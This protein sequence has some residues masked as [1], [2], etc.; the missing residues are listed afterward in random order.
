MSALR[1]LIVGEAELD[2]EEGDESFDEETGEVRRSKQG[3]NGL[4]G[5][6]GHYDDSSEEEED[7]NDEEAARQVIARAQA[8]SAEIQ[9]M[10]LLSMA[11]DQ[12]RLHCRRR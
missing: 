7:D 4:N 1:D 9:L 2:D 3:T 12:G 10:T 8:F 11:I 5:A 6:N